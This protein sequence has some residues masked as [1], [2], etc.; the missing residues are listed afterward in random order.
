MPEPVMAQGP[1]AFF[2]ELPIPFELQHDGPG[3]ERGL[4]YD[5]VSGKYAE[6][7][8][9]E[10]LPKV[11]KDYNVRLTKDPQ[12]RVTIGGSS[13]GIAAFTVAWER[14]D[15][16]R[17][18]LSTVGSFVNLRGGDAY[19]SL[20][21]KTERKPLRVFLEDATGDL[22]NA[23]GNWPLANQQMHAALKYMGYD[24]RFDWAEGYAHNSDFGGAKFPDAM[25]WLWRKD[26]FT[27]VLDTRGDLV[28]STC[29]GDSGGSAAGAGETVATTKKPTTAR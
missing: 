20:I 29:A 11:E 15:A 14:P 3:S 19:P 2:R 16:F 27:P 18:V 4:E 24:V 26:K 28:H 8:E 13:G 1:V 25:K 7:V 10:I 9:A 6:F 21:R 12:G 5:T 22:D 17:K 23:F